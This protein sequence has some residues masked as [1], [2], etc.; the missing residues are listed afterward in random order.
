M[1]IR[2]MVK[3]RRLRLQDAILLKCAQCWLALG[4]VE[5]AQRELRKLNPRAALH[6]EA[7]K[8][9]RELQ[10]ALAHSPQPS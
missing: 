8:V 4:I 9:F 1:A 5:E 7:L 2:T 6:P 10:Q 3:P